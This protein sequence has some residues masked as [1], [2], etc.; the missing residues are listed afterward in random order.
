MVLGGKRHHGGANPQTHDK[1]YPLRHE[2]TLSATASSTA[3]SVVKNK[4]ASASHSVIRDE[5]RKGSAPE[6]N[7]WAFPIASRNSFKHSVWNEG[8]SGCG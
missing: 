2:G 5:L 7:A 8:G 6:L 1:Y 4:P 3:T